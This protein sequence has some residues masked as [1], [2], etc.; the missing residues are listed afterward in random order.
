MEVTGD[1]FVFCKKKR[2]KNN[3]DFAFS[4]S[5]IKYLPDIRVFN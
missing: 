4:S 3:D 5:F 2:I 1:N